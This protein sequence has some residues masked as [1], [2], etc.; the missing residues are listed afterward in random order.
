MAR[1]V[2]FVG[3]GLVLQDL[4]DDS[5]VGFGG[6]EDLREDQRMRWSAR[7]FAFVFSDPPCSGSGRGGSWWWWR[8]VGVPVVALSGAWWVW[9]QGVSM[10]DGGGD[11]RLVVVRSSQSACLVHVAGAFEDIVG[12][13]PVSSLLEPAGNGPVVFEGVVEAC[14]D[15]HFYQPVVDS[16]LGVVPLSPVMAQ[17]LVLFLQFLFVEGCLS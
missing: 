10:R 17:F 14:P 5:A 12:A 11:K 6:D 15:P 7:S 16:L 3:L 1:F 2:G 4:R 9:R 8:W 13:Q